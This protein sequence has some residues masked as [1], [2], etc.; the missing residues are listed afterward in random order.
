MLSHRLLILTCILLIPYSCKDSVEKPED[1]VTK[2]ID[3]MKWLVGQWVRTND[4]EGNLTKEEWELLPTGVL[5]GIA[6]TTNASTDTTF[7]EKMIIHC[8]T[9]T[10]CAMTV[11]IKDEPPTRFSLTPSNNSF[12]CYN[13]DNPFPKKILYKL[14]KEGMEAVISGGGPTIPFLYSRADN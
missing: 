9:P 14:T 10:L 1:K 8:T 11:Y 4:A 12:T 7:N 5:S 6:Y 13:E 3:S 2:V